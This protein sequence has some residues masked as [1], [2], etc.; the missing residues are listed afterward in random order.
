MCGLYPRGIHD[1][2]KSTGYIYEAHLRDELTRR[3]SVQ[4]EAKTGTADAMPK[5]GAVAAT[6]L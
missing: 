3:L 5:W 6:S 1:H 2:L 4:W